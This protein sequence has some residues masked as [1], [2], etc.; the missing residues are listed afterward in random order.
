MIWLIGCKGMLGTQISNELTRNGS[1]FTSTDI[2]T[3]ITDIDTLRKFAEGKDISTI[4]NAS[5]YTAV[6]KAENE[7][8]KA[9]AINAT[10]TCNIAKVAS[11]INADV[12]HF[13]TDYVFDGTKDGAY[14]EDDAVN[15]VSAYG[16][17]K[18]A[19]E[20]ALKAETDRYYIFRISWLYG[21]YGANFVKTMVRL[22]SERDELGIVS[23]RKAVREHHQTIKHPRQ[24]VRHIPLQRHGQHQLA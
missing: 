24:E 11:E 16:R 14:T 8:E 20:E 3:D 10:G 13:S 5:A 23:V 9:L 1:T 22:M 19:G 17:T 2:E 21:V 4:I 7:E 12:I 6:D 15:P 18:L